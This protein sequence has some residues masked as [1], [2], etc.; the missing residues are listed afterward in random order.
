MATTKPPAPAG[1]R[2]DKSGKLVANL[3]NEAPTYVKPTTAQ[4]SA[5]PTTPAGNNLHWEWNGAKWVA[6]PNKGAPAPTQ[7][8]TSTSTPTIITTPSGQ[9]ETTSPWQITASQLY[10]WIAELYNYVPELQSL[11]DAAKNEKW[12]GDRFDNAIKSTVWWRSKDA[13][14]RAYLDKQ[15]TDPTTLANDIKA[16][17]FEIETYIGGLGYSLDSALAKSLAEQSIRY[18]WN[19]EEQARYVGAEVAKTG[20]TGTMQGAS[21]ISGGLAA[22]SIRQFAQD[23]GIK[24]DDTTVN[25]YAQSLISKTMTAEQIKQTLRQDAENLYP[26]LRGQLQTGRT[27]AQATATYRALAASLLGI[28]PAMVDFTDP[29]KFGRLLSYQDPNTNES[30]LMNVGEW[31]QFLRTLPE[32]Q[33]T[34]EA[35]NVYR[36]VASTIVRGFGAV[37]G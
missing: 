13:K 19:A 33:Q 7:T 18:G 35:K 5:K 20:K 8:S 6:V 12:T 17:Q 30:R 2:Y 14:E 10:G 31:G 32:W 29:N 21:A 26:A 27:V 3:G 4:Q 36:D 24:L 34:D 16:K 28:D 11:I 22:A 23:Y 37:K 9:V 15:I 25:S 1:Y